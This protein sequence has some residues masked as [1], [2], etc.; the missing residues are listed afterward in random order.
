MAVITRLRHG[1]RAM[2]TSVILHAPEETQ[3][4][5]FAA[6]VRTV[7]GVFVEG[8]L[9]FSRFRGESELSH[10][11]REAGAWTAVSPAF[12]ALLR[13]SLSAAERSDGL[14]D[15]T[16]LGALVA[17]GYDRD[18]DEVVAGARIALRP[19]TPGGR[20]RDI[21]LAPGRVRLPEGVGIDLGGIAKGWAVDRA[22]AAALDAGLAWALV[23]AGGDL[24]VVGAAP[25]LA[26]T[27]QDPE[28]R[29]ESCLRV[30]LREG[31]IA[32]SSVTR[33]RWGADRHHLIDPRTG[34]PADT[35][36]LQASAWAPTCAAAEVAA[37]VLLF[38]GA[39]AL[40]DTPGVVV[41]AEGDVVTN[42]SGT[43]AA[44]A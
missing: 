35:G 20:W 17:A 15:P 16:V 21:D 29:G 11:N 32:T 14:F 37:K 3:P 24:R 41:L 27:I 43:G 34:L 13:A 30:A 38:R 39:D 18:F 10:V 26:V 19:G 40:S 33:R 25:D 7:E 2:G 31:A 12:E 42:L 9:R 22:A 23:G 1:L 8:E 44:A 4:E 5:A 28:V 6:A 36:V